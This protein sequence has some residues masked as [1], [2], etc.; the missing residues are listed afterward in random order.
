MVC[1]NG[2]IPIWGFVWGK[3]KN[4]S[5]F[6]ILQCKGLRISKWLDSK[7][8]TFFFWFGGWITLI[9]FS[10]SIIILYFLS[11]LKIPAGVASKIK[12]IMCN[13]LQFGVGS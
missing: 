1:Y 8:G 12:H 7:K 10:I 11:S 6:G 9:Q 4:M 2:H 5:H 13:F 3:N